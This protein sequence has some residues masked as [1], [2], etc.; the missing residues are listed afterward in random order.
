MNIIRNPSFG[1]LVVAAV[2]ISGAATHA[3]AEEVLTPQMQAYLKAHSGENIDASWERSFHARATDAMNENESISSEA[4]YA[5]DK[6]LDFFFDKKKHFEDHDSDPLSA[7][8]KLE[9]ARWYLLY[10]NNGWAFP[11]R[12]ST[13]LTRSY[14]DKYMESTSDRTASE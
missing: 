10:I 11:T 6:L 5:N 13:Y 4:T 3:Y 1:V 8:D 7:N 14:F 9:I 12:V 2:L